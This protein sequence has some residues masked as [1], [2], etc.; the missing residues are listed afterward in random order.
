MKKKAAEISMLRIIKTALNPRIKLR[1]VT[2]RADFPSC[3]F[4]L[5]K[6]PRYEGIKGSTQGERNESSPAVKTSSIEGYP[7]ISYINLLKS[8]HYSKHIFLT[9]LYRYDILL[10]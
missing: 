6:I 9:L 10:W 4:A 2:N 3:V 8:N 7:F 1:V 5:P